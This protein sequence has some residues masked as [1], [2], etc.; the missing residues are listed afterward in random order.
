MHQSNVSK[1]I[2]LATCLIAILAGIFQIGKLLGLAIY[3]NAFSVNSIEI[4][5]VG[6]ISSGIWGVF[7]FVRT[8]KKLQTS[9]KYN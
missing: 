2:L 5:Q 7:E 9:P 1:W 4:W 6:L 3:S 8:M